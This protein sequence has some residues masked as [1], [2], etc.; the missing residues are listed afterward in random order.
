MGRIRTV[1][2]EFFQDEELSSLPEITHLLAG[3]LLCYSDDDGYFNANHGL[4]KAAIFPLRESSVSIHDMLMQ[5]A[6][7][8]FI[9]LGKAVDGKH[10]GQV[11]K[12]SQHQ[13]VNRPTPSKIKTLA[14]Q[15]IES[16]SPHGG[17]TEDSLQEGKGKEG[18]GREENPSSEQESRSD[19]GGAPT[20]N[21]TEKALSREACRLAALLKSEILRNKPG[22][23]ITPAQI[24]KW[25]LTADRMLL[26]DGRTPDQIADLIR[27]AQHNEFWMTNVLSM[28][29]LREKFD[30][31]EMKSELKSHSGDKS[32]PVKLPD[33]YVPASERILQERSARAGGAQ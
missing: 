10:Y 12:F 8:G 26:L 30:Q 15:W 22:Y 17:L 20:S 5:L 27:W 14:I 11:V 6:S 4:V 16:V 32:A 33:N 2:P 29:T 9:R 25:E 23:R 18:K 21:K 28:D 19:Q 24:R 7:I 31:L 13:R 3:G 1:K